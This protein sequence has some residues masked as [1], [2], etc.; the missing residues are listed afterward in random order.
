MYDIEASVPGLNAS[1]AVEVRPGTASVVPI[2]LSLADVANTVD[3]T[4]NDS[5]ARKQP[6]RAG[7]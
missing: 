6:M 4:A 2:E 3:V 7:W 5:P 1:L